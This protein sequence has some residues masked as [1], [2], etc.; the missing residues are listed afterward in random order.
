MSSMN[1]AI[2]SNNTAPG[3]SEVTNMTHTTTNLELKQ[4]GPDSRLAMNVEKMP[5]KHF[6]RPIVSTSC[7]DGN[8]DAIVMSDSAIDIHAG[9]AR[10]PGYVTPA[11]LYSWAYSSSWTAD[12]TG[13]TVPLNVSN[14]MAA[15]RAFFYYYHCHMLVKLVCKMPLDRSDRFYLNWSDLNVGT[16]SNIGVGFEWAPIEKNEIYVMLP[17]SAVY[18]MTD[19]SVNQADIFGYLN[20]SQIGSNGQPVVIDAYTCPVQQTLFNLR[21][22]STPAPSCKLSPV[23]GEFSTTT[24]GQIFAVTPE[25]VTSTVRV[26]IDGRTLMEESAGE[27][28][29][30]LLDLA[31]GNHSIVL[32]GDVDVYTTATVETAA[33]TAELQVNDELE[34]PG[35]TSEEVSP[36]DQV[37]H[38]PDIA[39]KQLSKVVY[40]S[41]NTESV[42]E[43]NQYYLVGSVNIDSKTPVEFTF[44]FPEEVLINF[45]RHHLWTKYLSVKLVATQTIQNP[46]RYRIVQVP[47]VGSL[48]FS[49]DQFFELPGIEWDP[50][51][52]D[53]DLSLYWDRPNAAFAY[54][55]TQTLQENITSFLPRL[56]VQPINSYGNSVP[57]NIFASLDHSSYSAI[58]E[59]S[60]PTATAEEQIR[61]DGLKHCCA[62]SCSLVGKR[63]WGTFNC[64]RCNSE[65]ECKC[66]CVTFQQQNLNMYRHHFNPYVK[67]NTRG[68]ITHKFYDREEYRLVSTIEYNG[69]VYFQINSCG[70]RDEELQK[71]ETE[72]LLWLNHDIHKDIMAKQGKIY[73]WRPVTRPIA[74]VW[75]YDDIPPPPQPPVTAAPTAVEQVGPA[76]SPIPGDQFQSLLTHLNKD[77]GANRVAQ[78]F[79]FAETFELTVT[80]TD[81]T[82]AV[83][84]PIDANL[85]GPYVRQEARRHRN[86]RGNL[87][88]KILF[89]TPRTVAGAGTVAHL[90]MEPATQPTQYVLRQYPHQTTMDDSCLEL[91]CGWRK[92]NPWVSRSE[93]NGF[94]YITFN[95]ALFGSS[96]NTV[97]VTIYVDASGIEFARPTPLAMLPA[98]RV[99][100]VPNQIKPCVKDVSMRAVE[101]SLQGVDMTFPDIVSMYEA[102]LFFNGTAMQCPTCNLLIG[103]WED[104]DVPLLEHYRHTGAEH[105][106]CRL[107]LDRMRCGF[108]ERPL[109]RCSINALNSRLASTRMLNSTSA[110]MEWD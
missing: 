19:P 76:D 40:G 77:E 93:N 96:Q 7:P 108:P 49:G 27:F 34:L 102:G 47:Q 33:A 6:G 89:N 28:K 14:R 97:K 57:I 30:Y 100:M 37:G 60:L 78:T 42:R 63:Y 67:T 107:V 32:S 29:S 5:G 98:T 103:D 31:V 95:G 90:D 41:N 82:P 80:Q 71:A 73:K 18:P 91:L 83:V 11:H 12:A 104:G 35:S 20:I 86:W 44:S 50:K 105:S 106:H 99:R 53:L 2:F 94:L 61:F 4:T 62:N 15:Y 64:E 3:E 21:P 16:K 43:T 84:I 109:S 45:A 9:I 68:L 26:T 22:I 85:L 46:G 92:E 72:N 24:A 66:H 38:S 25:G 88:F 69:K 55:D 17:W 65:K 54:D 75:S 36:S 87:R 52:G 81:P 59:L 8:V 56:Y 51:D 101:L 23:S 48:D 1:R 110:A 10:N 13:Q 58:K 39:S 79:A 70:D 74:Y